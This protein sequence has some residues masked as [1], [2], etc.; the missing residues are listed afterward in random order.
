MK[1]IVYRWGDAAN[2]DR[3]YVELAEG[4]AMDHVGALFFMGNNKLGIAKYVH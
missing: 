2:D 4:E 3:I 1:N